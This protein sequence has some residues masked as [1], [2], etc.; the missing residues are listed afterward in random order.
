MDNLTHSLIG[1]ALARTAP[2]FKRP[3]SDNPRLQRALLVTGILA[4]NAPDCDFLLQ[5]FFDTGGG[6]QLFYLLHHRGYTHT[7]LGLA[8]LALLCAGL[9][10]L[11]SR[12]GRRGKPVAWTALLPL[13]LVGALVHV[14][15]DS[16][17]EYGVHPFSPFYNRWFYG[18]SIF[19]VEPLLWCALLPLAFGRARR[20]SYLFVGAVPLYGWF[21]G[22]VPSV[23]LLWIYGALVCARAIQAVRAR[24]PRLVLGWLAVVAVLGTFV[25]AGNVAR[26][27]VRALLQAQ[28]PGE[29]PIDLVL[30]PG[31]ANP[32]CWR[33]IPVSS[34]ATEYVARIG[35]ISLAPSLIAP[36]RCLDRL[37]TEHAAPVSAPT[38]ASSDAVEWITEFRGRRAEFDRLSAESC[39]FVALLRFAR[40]PFWG[41]ALGGDFR[42]DRARGAG[43]ATVRLDGEE[44][45]RTLPPWTPPFSPARDRA[46][47]RGAAAP[48]EV[49][50]H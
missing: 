42:Y 6:K 50:G 9:G 39:R 30:S 44:C 25:V 26:G 8:L 5:R 11:S 16:W 46:P 35:V 45:P 33:A 17:N 12:L 27:R 49:A 3:G 29:T 41:P 18:D 38:L 22:Y 19:I 10:A 7:V 23:A 32:F 14:G 36:E 40:V 15:A 2:S 20:L 48:G 24:E 1:A 31:P 43:F 13:A 21:A 37:R 34:T 28:A 4:S 47:G